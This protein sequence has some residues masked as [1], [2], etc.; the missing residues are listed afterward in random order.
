MQSLNARYFYKASTT[1]E[2]EEYGMYGRKDDQVK[3]DLAI[4]LMTLS[5]STFLLIIYLIQTAC[6]RQHLGWSHLL[7]T[8][9]TIFQIPPFIALILIDQLKFDDAFK[10]WKE[11]VE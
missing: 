11:L 2:S 1:E 9:W 10:S 8:A 4:A 5:I 6:K 3:L 7:L